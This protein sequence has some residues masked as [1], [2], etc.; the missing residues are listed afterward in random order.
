MVSTGGMGSS[1]GA[2][3]AVGGLSGSTAA[4][5]P[6]PD[7]TLSLVLETQEKVRRKGKKKTNVAIINKPS[8]A[9]I[10]IPTQG[11]PPVIQTGGRGGLNIVET[12][13]K[14]HRV[15]SGALF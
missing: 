9:P 15:N 8:P 7:A 10:T 5:T 12:R 1:T 2:S 11:E 3:S 13:R 6:V 4:L 14:L